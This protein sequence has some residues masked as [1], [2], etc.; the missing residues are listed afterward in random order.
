[1]IPGLLRKIGRLELKVKELN[2]EVEELTKDNVELIAISERKE[3]EILKLKKKQ[4]QD[5]LIAIIEL[6]EGEIMKLKKKQS[7]Q[8]VLVLAMFI[9]VLVLVFSVMY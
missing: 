2:D 3:A 1:M 8:M 4:S 6:K 7:Q 5:N 9:T